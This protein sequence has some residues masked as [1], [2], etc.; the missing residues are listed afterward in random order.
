MH[1]DPVGRGERRRWLSLT[2][3]VDVVFLLLI[4]FMLTTSF[5]QQRNITL[6]VPGSSSEDSTR[7][8]SAWVGSMLVRVR[9]GGEIE[10]GRERVMLESISGKVITLIVDAPDM[11][12]IVRPDVGIPLQDVVLVLDQLRSGGAAQVSLIR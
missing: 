3:L 10:F 8:K 1:F 2:S 12:F 9:S 7:T 4:F 6:D 5:S 11:R